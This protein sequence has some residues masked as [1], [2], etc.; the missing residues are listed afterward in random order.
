MS[1]SVSL[2]LDRLPDNTPRR[3]RAGDYRFSV[4]IKDPAGQPAITIRGF[5]IDPHFIRIIPPATVYNERSVYNIAI[6]SRSIDD[7]LLA[8][9]RNEIEGTH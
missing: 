6:L 2:T 9:L 4:V 8:A 1:Y 5:R 3:T 7:Q